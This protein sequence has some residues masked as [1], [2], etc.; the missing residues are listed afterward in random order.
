MFTTNLKFYIKVWATHSSWA[1]HELWSCRAIFWCILRFYH[2]CKQHTPFDL[3]L[4]LG[5]YVENVVK[6]IPYTYIPYVYLCSGYKEAASSSENRRVERLKLEWISYDQTF[7]NPTK[8]TKHTRFSVT[9]NC[10]F[11]LVSVATNCNQKNLRT[12]NHHSLSPRGYNTVSIG[13][14]QLTVVAFCLHLLEQAVPKSLLFSCLLLKK[15][16]LRSCE[17]SGNTTNWHAVTSQ[18]IWIFSNATVR[19]PSL[20]NKA[21]PERGKMRGVMACRM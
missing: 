3:L 4:K 15:T 5:V 17:T 10:D 8:F 1:W 6:N 12:T 16:F 9:N 13:R 18:K 14:C 20:V 7:S 11:H 2:E 21:M 19:I